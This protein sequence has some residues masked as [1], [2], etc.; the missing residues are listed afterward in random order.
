MEKGLA[1]IENRVQGLS[2]LLYGGGPDTNSTRPLP[3][4][5][6]APA[7]PVYYWAWVTEQGGRLSNF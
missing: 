3:Y 7:G 1:K 4:S 5:M 6:I 2:A